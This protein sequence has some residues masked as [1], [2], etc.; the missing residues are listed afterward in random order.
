MLHSLDPASDRPAYKQIADQLRAAIKAGEFQPGLRL[1]SEAELI[2]QFEVSQGTIRQA[3]NLL[4]SEGLVHSQQGRGVFVRERPRIRRLASDRFL[5]RHR[6]EGKAAYLAESE[7]SGVRPEVEVYFVGPS[8]APEEIAGLLNLRRGAKVLVRRR[9]YL[10]NGHPTEMATSYIPWA[11][12]KGT[13]M[14]E[15]NPGPGGIYARL[16]E[17]GYRLERFKEEVGARMPSPEEVK[18]LQLASGTPVLTLVRTAFAADDKPVEVC[19]TVLA[20][21]LY[22][23][24][25]D[26]PAR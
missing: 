10:S 21:D 14:V 17:Q 12:A 9:R 16:E 1:P 3:L 8:D 24:D 2:A 18:A 7:A 15:P 19:D 25:Y 6:D 22:R 11:L 26:L 5:R 23:L 13:A 20:A 4:K